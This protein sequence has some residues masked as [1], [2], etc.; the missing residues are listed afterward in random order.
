MIARLDAVSD[1]Y[2]MLYS[3]TLYASAVVGLISVFSA[4]ALAF[5]D[6]QPPLAPTDALTREQLSLEGFGAA[7]PAC[8]EWNDGCATCRREVSGDAHCSTPGIACQPTEL[9]CKARRP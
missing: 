8:L 6:G 3:P 2:E 7:N 5:A 9:L 1:I 4:A